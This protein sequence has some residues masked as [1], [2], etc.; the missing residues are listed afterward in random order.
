MSVHLPTS[1]PTL[2]PAY[3]ISRSAAAGS[4]CVLGPL[5][6]A[7]EMPF[8][9]SRSSSCL[10]RGFPP[11]TTPKPLRGSSSFA[12]FAKAD[13]SVSLWFYRMPWHHSHSPRSPL[14]LSSRS[15]SRIPKAVNPPETVLRKCHAGNAFCCLRAS[16]AASRAARAAAWVEGQWLIIFGVPLHGLLENTHLI[17]LRRKHHTNGSFLRPRAALACDSEAGAGL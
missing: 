2:T 7:I 16:A 5:C 15:C 8:V 11:P 1:A 13:N 4:A 17:S 10:T 9:S 6:V 3:H 14:S 12:P